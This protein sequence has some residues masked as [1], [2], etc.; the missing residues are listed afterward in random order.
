MHTKKKLVAAYPAQTIETVGTIS[1]PLTG[2]ACR[3]LLPN[4]KSAV[5]YMQ[6]HTAEHVGTL[7]CGDRVQ[8]TLSPADFD[9]A[10][11]IARLPK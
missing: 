10:R 4:G 2:F 7:H 3:A 8:L 5:A 6:R 11:I 1:E 9:C